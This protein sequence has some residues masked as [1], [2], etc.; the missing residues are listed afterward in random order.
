MT[1]NTGRPGARSAWNRTSIGE[2]GRVTDPLRT[3]QSSIS[4]R[5]R[6]LP[7]QSTARTI[8]PSIRAAPYPDEFAGSPP[9]SS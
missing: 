1:P 9:L 8:G 6:L 4:L 5:C 7:A 3:H 2:Q